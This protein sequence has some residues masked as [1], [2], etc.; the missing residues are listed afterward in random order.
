MAPR[1]AFPRPRHPPPRRMEAC[2]R[3]VEARATAPRRK[4]LA[5]GIGCSA[6]TTGIPQVCRTYRHFTLAAQ[7]K[8]V[9]DAQGSCRN[10]GQW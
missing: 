8:E 3:R 7:A 6:K 1:S 9:I 2:V 4:A 5:S 10:R